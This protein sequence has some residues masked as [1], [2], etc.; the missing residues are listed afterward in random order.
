M[1]ESSRSDKTGFLSHQQSVHMDVWIEK[2]VLDLHL[3]LQS[4]SKWFSG[5][6]KGSLGRQIETL[7]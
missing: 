4:G 3:C 6:P 7:I 1:E 2:S 5:H